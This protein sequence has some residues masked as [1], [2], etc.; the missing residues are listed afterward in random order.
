MFKIF[1]LILLCFS[2]QLAASTL[3]FATTADDYPPYTFTDAQGNAQGIYVDIAIRVSELI[4][5]KADVRPLPWRRATNWVRN[6][7]IDSLLISYD[8][9]NNR[10]KFWIFPGS[11]LGTTSY[12]VCTFKNHP[13]AFENLS[14]EAIPKDFLISTVDGYE[15]AFGENATIKNRTKAIARSEPHLIQLLINKRLEAI[16][17]EASTYQN[18][19]NK[20]DIHCFTGSIAGATEYIAFSKKSVSKELAQQFANAMGRFK[21]SDEFRRLL[22]KYNLKDL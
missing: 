5:K 6:G 16:L 7:T 4:D 8:I 19:P 11:E 17:I 14:V 13:L 9:K 21:K 15:Y 3:S 18:H 20:S 12:K 22:K 1:L 2:S 10:E